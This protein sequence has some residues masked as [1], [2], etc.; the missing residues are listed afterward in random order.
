MRGAEHCFVSAEAWLGRRPEPLDRP[1]ALARL[2]RRYLAAHGPAN[3]R[4]LAKWAGRHPRRRARGLA[5]IEDE[6]VHRPDG[7]VDLAG[8][9]PAPPPPPPRLLGS[10][11]PLLHGWVSR[12]A[13]VGDHEGSSP[14]T[15][16]S[17]RSRSWTVARSR[18]GGSP[19]GRI[20]IR[21]L[22]RIAQPVL[23]ALEHDA[24]DV[25]RFLGLPPRPAVVE[26]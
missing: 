7:L 17:G 8:R 6:L 14:A 10:Y 3:D 25:L 18:R 15:A 11:D 20:T 21:P 2:G 5:A 4:D 9:G 24:L 26:R 1:A 22:E 13:V 12:D 16:S 23:R 19:S